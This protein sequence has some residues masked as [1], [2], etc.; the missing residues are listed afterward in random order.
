MLDGDWSSDVCSSDL[1][2]YKTGLDFI[3]ERHLIVGT[4]AKNAENDYLN[5]IHQQ[6]RDYQDKYPLITTV[7]GNFHNSYL[8]MAAEGGA[9]F[10]S[11]YLV[12]I[13][14]LILQ[15]ALKLIRGEVTDRVFPIA[16]LVVTL[17]GMI[18]Y[19]FHGELYR[20]GGIVFNLVLIGGCVFGILKNKENGYGHV[21]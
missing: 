21:H 12:G 6:S 1:Q 19:F 14:Y 4:G 8:Q 3:I 5:F 7:P 13:G 16:A 9:L 20:Y 15:M 18:T 2:M 10:L 11:A 17:G